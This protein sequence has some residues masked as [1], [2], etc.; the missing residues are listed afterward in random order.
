MASSYRSEQRRESTIGLAVMAAAAI[1]VLTS[2]ILLSAFLTPSAS[3]VPP[4]TVIGAG[5]LEDL[6]I[7]QPV[8][9]PEGNLFV[10]RLT[11]KTVIALS[12]VNTHQTAC[13]IAW[14]PDF[15]LQGKYAWFRDPC[16]GSTFDLTGNRVS[17]PAPAGMTRYEVQIVP[18]A[19]Q[20]GNRVHVLT[21]P[22]HTTAGRPST[23]PR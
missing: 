6:P 10:V 9:I 20:H 17:G 18:A 5:I 8:Y 7:R 2:F 21:A 15:R 19:P 16:V 14:L 22:R 3:A 12:A 23:V 11:E 1:A 13:T 4:K